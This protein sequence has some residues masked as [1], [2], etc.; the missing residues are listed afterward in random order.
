MY[1]VKVPLLFCL[2]FVAIEL[3]M[4]SRAARGRVGEPPPPAPPAQR[5]WGSGRGWCRACNWSR[6]VCRH[7]GNAS[8]GGKV[9]VA[10]VARLCVCQWIVCSPCVVRVFLGTAGS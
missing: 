9:G 7:A 5:L 6:C 2:Y 1:V 10:L 8:V 3:H 4:R